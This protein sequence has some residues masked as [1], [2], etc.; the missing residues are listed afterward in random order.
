MTYWLLNN[1]LFILV[2]LNDV[3]MFGLTE[4]RP[5]NILHILSTLDWLKGPYFFHKIKDTFFI[6]TNNFIDLDVLSISAISRYGF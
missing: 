4:V 2:T 1:A 3:N 5:F 6:F